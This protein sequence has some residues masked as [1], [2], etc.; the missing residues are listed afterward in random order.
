[1][2]VAMIDTNYLEWVFD[3]NTSVSPT[4]IYS[5]VRALGAQRW[6][7]GET[8]RE[9][10]LE[11]DAIYV[12]IA[13]DNLNADLIP[14]IRKRF[15]DIPLVV[16]VD[17]SVALWRE[18]YHIPTLRRALL[19]ADVIF[20]A[21][22]S[23]VRL[24]SYICSR[25]VALLPHPVDIRGI[26]AMRT[27]PTKRVLGFVHRYDGEWLMPA[28]VCHGI[29]CETAAIVAGDNDPVATLCKGWF[30]T[31]RHGW[32]NIDQHLKHERAPLFACVDS[33]HGVPAM[34]RIQMENAVLGVPTIGTSDV[35]MQKHLWP[36]LTT[37]SF[38][39]PT[40]RHLLERILDDTSFREAQKN[41][42]RAAVQPYGLQ[43]SKGRFEALVREVT[44]V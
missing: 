10:S 13:P 12:N 43:E 26:E 28:L 31:A 16:S 38:D 5:W 7:W 24:T 3:S 36:G 41:D 6:L 2:R 23:I 34:G 9:Q 44:D 14:Q 39:V 20:G 27:K 11:I 33:Y 30:D 40:Q 22:P 35:Y 15:P 1:M 8:R 18:K 29:T 19:Y 17:Y 4:G 21:E 32:A 37:D 42:A 25:N